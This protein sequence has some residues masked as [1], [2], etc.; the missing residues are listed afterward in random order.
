MPLNVI[1]IIEAAPVDL[2]A[3]TELDLKFFTIDVIE[4]LTGYDTEPLPNTK[5]THAGQ[6][7]ILSNPR[8]EPLTREAFNGAKGNTLLCRLKPYQNPEFGISRDLKSE[9]PTMDEFFLVKPGTVQKEPPPNILPENLLRP[10]YTITPPEP[11]I[12]IG[13]D[14]PELNINVFEPIPNINEVFNITNQAISNPVSPRKKKKAKLEMKPWEW[15]VEMHEKNQLIEGEWEEVVAE[16]TAEKGGKP[17]VF[18]R[19]GEYKR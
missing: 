1:S 2:A 12:I 14:L 3:K 8:W 5:L 15:W 17:P 10:G 7:T 16:K 4:M 19:N 6:P 13:N 9:F 18:K 11:V